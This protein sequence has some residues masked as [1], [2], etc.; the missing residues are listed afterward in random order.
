MFGFG[1]SSADAKKDADIV[2]GDSEYAVVSLRPSWAMLSI[3]LAIYSLPLRFWAR[4]MPWH[5]AQYWYQPRLMLGGILAV[6]ALGAFFGWL[7]LRLGQG[8]SLAKV[9]LFLNI[10]VASVLFLFA[11]FLTAYF[12]FFR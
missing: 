12:R 11:G 6:A 8:R 2:V 5:P 9:G 7:G 4:H 1:S 10:T 3:A